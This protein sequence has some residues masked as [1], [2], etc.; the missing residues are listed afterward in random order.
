MGSRALELDPDLLEALIAN[1]PEYSWEDQARAPVPSVGPPPAFLKNRYAS[2]ARF[3][4]LQASA[5]LSRRDSESGGGGSN[6]RKSKRTIAKANPK[7]SIANNWTSDTFPF[8]Y[9]L[10]LPPSLLTPLLVLKATDPLPQSSVVVSPYLRIPPY[11]YCARTSGYWRITNVN[12]LRSRCHMDHI[13]F[14]AEYEYEN[15]NEFRDRIT[16]CGAKVAFHIP[17]EDENDEPEKL[18]STGVCG[19]CLTVGCIM[20][21]KRFFYLPERVRLIRFR[22]QTE[23]RQSL[24][25][26]LAWKRSLARQSPCYYLLKPIKLRR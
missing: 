20:H 8:N 7:H 12:S 22:L 10:P 14:F 17:N 1:V 23:P 25:R 2:G 24:C 11:N 19:I 5:A 6:A 18:P 21:R 13:P 9:T 26:Q 16:D 15:E 4:E 3:A